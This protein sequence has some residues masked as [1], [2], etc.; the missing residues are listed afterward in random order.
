MKPG[1]VVALGEVLP[2]G[3]VGSEELVGVLRFRSFR[4]SAQFDSLL[5]LCLIAGLLRWDEFR[6][7]CSWRARAWSIHSCA[8]STSST[9]DWNFFSRSVEVERADWSACSAVRTGGG[10]SGSWSA[11]LIWPTR[12]VCS[13]PANSDLRASRIVSLD[14]G[15]AAVWSFLDACPPAGGPVLQGSPPQNPAG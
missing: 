11:C 4:M 9:A 7:A 12:S 3:R 13:S 1:G 5:F 6:A 14:G 8:S 15:W 2:D 10:L